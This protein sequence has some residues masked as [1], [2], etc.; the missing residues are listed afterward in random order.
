MWRF[1]L[2]ARD[3][4]QCSKA[5]FL[6]NGVEEDPEFSPFTAR[7][8]DQVVFIVREGCPTSMREALHFLLGLCAVAPTALWFED[9]EVKW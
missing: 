8:K 2:T 4:A 6:E 3:A 5:F 7:D 9:N 1:A